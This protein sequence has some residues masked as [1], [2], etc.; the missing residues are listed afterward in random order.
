[1][2]TVIKVKLGL[3]MMLASAAM[4]AVDLTNAPIKCPDGTRYEKKL[5][6]T[7]KDDFYYTE[8]CKDQNDKYQ[9]GIVKM[10]RTDETLETVYKFRPGTIEG[11]AYDFYA[12]HYAKTGRS[13]LLEYYRNDVVIHRDRLPGYWEGIAQTLEQHTGFTLAKPRIRY[14]DRKLTFTYEHLTSEQSAQLVAELEDNRA[15]LV[16]QLC[17]EANAAFM[18]QLAEDGIALETI[19]TDAQGKLLLKQTIAGQDCQQQKQ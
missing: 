9:G 4:A 13:E 14:Q 10:Y 16:H 15:Y 1:L 17:N 11:Q 2:L 12:I 6:N 18:A 19:F 5:T 7:G 8:G 3:F